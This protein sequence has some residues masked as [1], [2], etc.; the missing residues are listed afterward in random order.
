MDMKLLSKN[1]YAVQI[2]NTRD[3]RMKWWR[4]ARFGM[5]VHF[6]LY[7]VLGRHAW[8]PPCVNLQQDEY[9]TQAGYFQP[10]EGC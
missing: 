10:I 6:G 1:E 7:S 5:F 9:E 8:G 4:E 3:A 2:A